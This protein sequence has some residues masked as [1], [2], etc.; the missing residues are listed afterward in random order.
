VKWID[1]VK[2]QY[3][4]DLKEDGLGY[5]SQSENKTSETGCQ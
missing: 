5:Q 2:K 3:Y 4:K 1:K